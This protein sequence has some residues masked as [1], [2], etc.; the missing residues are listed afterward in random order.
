MIMNMNAPELLIGSGLRT[1]VGTLIHDPDTEITEL[2]CH[3]QIPIIFT[4]SAG[5][6]SSMSRFHLDWTD[7]KRDAPFG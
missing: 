5:A 1:I 2:R 4:I 7:L 3:G 6:R